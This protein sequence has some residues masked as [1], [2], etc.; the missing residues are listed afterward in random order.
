M[1]DINQKV[2]DFMKQRR[3]VP[4]KT[5]GGPGPNSAELKEMISIASRVPDHG[6]LA[7]WRFVEYSNAAKLR[8]CD[9]IL[10]RALEINADLDEEQQLVEKNRFPQTHGVVAMYSCPKKHPKVPVWEQELSAGAAA[11]NFLIA[12][13]AHGFDAQWYTGWYAF[14]P[15]LTLVLG[16]KDGERIV[17][18]FHIGKKLLPKTERARPNID[19]IFSTLES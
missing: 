9:A 18:F 11:M 15:K 19:D 7:P 6:K 13:N 10:K 2:I 16:A 8:L 17:G 1:S 5:L 14:D 4:S 3:S 12:A